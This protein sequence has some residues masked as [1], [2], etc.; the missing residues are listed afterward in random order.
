VWAAW[1]HGITLWKPP[2]SWSFV[3][4]YW[5]LAREPE[6]VLHNISAQMTNDK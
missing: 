6:A 5:S 2:P 4:G 1:L 3:I